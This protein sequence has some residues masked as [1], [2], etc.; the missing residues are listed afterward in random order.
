MFRQ[1]RFDG[2]TGGTSGRGKEETHKPSLDQRNPEIPPEPALKIQI[3]P[4]DPEKI[5]VREGLYKRIHAEIHH[6]DKE[7]E[8]RA[9][10][11]L[12]VHPEW[13]EV[14]DMMMED[15]DVVPEAEES[16]KQKRDEV[17]QGRRKRQKEDDIQ[18]EKRGHSPTVSLRAQNPEG[19][20]SED[21]NEVQQEKE[22]WQAPDKWQR[23]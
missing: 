7:A 20:Y 9:E 2:A 21:W 5:A 12:E 1:R 16:T 8:A 6:K 14:P 18:P 17:A 3:V 11:M 4:E 23:I 10:E 22:Q 15:E 19:F 13:N